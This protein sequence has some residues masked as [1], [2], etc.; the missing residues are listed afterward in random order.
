MGRRLSLVQKFKQQGRLLDIGC[1]EGTFL[2][3]AR[4]RGF[5]V[6][7][8]DL[9]PVAV[10]KARELYHLNVSIGFIG[11]IQVDKDY[12]VITAW[13]VLEHVPEPIHALRW[14][15]GQ[16]DDQG[17]IVVETPNCDSL[18]A[19]RMGASWRGWQPPFH[20]WHFTPTTLC[21]AL[22]RTGFQPLAVRYEA[23]S[24]MR[25]RLSHI[26][27]LKVAKGL[28]AHLWTGTSVTVVSRRRI[29]DGE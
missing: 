25:Q 12:D 28:L 20:L 14:I 21:E 22:K 10:A 19:R 9:S 15:H 16:L 13:H 4:D 7:G 11:G 29:E 23:S 2:A 24:Y 5:A 18:D 1:G 6:D 26:P 8:F 17:V 3:Y 27:V